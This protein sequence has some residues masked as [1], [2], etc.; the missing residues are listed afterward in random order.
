MFSYSSARISRTGTFRLGPQWGG[1]Y[2]VGALPAELSD[3]ASNDPE[4]LAGLAQAGERITLHSEEERTLD[5]RIAT[6]R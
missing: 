4:P 5:L 1:D 2:F 6:P 3:V